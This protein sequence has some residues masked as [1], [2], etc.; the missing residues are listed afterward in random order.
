M[1]MVTMFAGLLMECSL[2]CSF[3]SAR[4]IT[5]PRFTVQIARMTALCFYDLALSFHFI[6]WYVGSF[7]TQK[8]GKLACLYVV[9]NL[10]KI[11]HSKFTQKFIIS[12]MLIG[13]FIVRR[14]KNVTFP[15]LRGGKQKSPMKPGGFI[16]LQCL[17][18]LFNFY[19]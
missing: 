6:Y 13:K 8:I 18:M 14:K 11:P 17:E 5:R 16:R 7:Y 9:L 10:W 1:T 15:V 2:L 4:C 3:L 12:A 19:V